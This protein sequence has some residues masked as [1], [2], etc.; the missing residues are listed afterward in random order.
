M[1]SGEWE[2]ASGEWRVGSGEW[3]VGGVSNYNEPLIS[4]EKDLELSVS[5]YRIIEVDQ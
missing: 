2:V 1:G 3:L 5:V 4:H